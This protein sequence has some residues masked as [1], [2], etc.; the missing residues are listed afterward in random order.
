MY[1]KA[2]RIALYGFLL[3]SVFF[4]KDALS[5]YVEGIDTTDV[6][7]FGLD[8]AFRIITNGEINTGTPS[9]RYGLYS[10]EEGFFNYS[11]DDIKM[12]AANGYP[13]IGN[14]APII[15]TCFIIKK[16]DSTYS[17]IQV[18]NKLPDN[19]Y[20]FKFGTNTTP[21]DRL[22]ENADYDRSVLYKPNNVL[23]RYYY[24]F[25]D[26]LFWEPPL[27]NNN[28]LLGYIFYGTK[29]VVIDT[30]APIIPAQ[31]DS[32]AYTTSTCLSFSPLVPR[33]LNLV[34]V[35]TEGKS[36]FLQGWTYFAPT[37]VGV[38]RFSAVPSK[39]LQM[40]VI[41]KTASGILL[42]VQPLP[43]N[44]GSSSLAIYNI[45]GQRIVQFSNLR[46]NSIFWNTS[47]RNFAEGLYILRAEL[48][49]RGV[50]YQTL[51]FTR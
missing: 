5:A 28:H 12:S 24:P 40:I 10:G 45:T 42:S 4:L 25:V 8:S 3:I 41:K 51:M 17:K 46:S 11:F 6:N 32:C 26:S 13:F 23:S 31:W 50:I 30:T 14:H 44:A 16:K 9:N 39:L 49:D 15:F 43:E 37:D 19:R 27:P 47:N 21:N 22:L 48:P 7:G 20:L 29:P 35:Y 34:A 2:S 38:S 18:L 33:Y 36:D 1:N